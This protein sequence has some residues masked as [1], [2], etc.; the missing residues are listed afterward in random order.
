V[1]TKT[2]A[3]TAMAGAQTTINNQLKAV[4]AKAKETATMT[5]MT[6]NENKGNEGGDGSLTAAWWRWWWQHS[7]GGGHVKILRFCHSRYLEVPTMAK[8]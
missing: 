4:A 3:A 8:A 1:A 5:A 2:L 7:V 6:T